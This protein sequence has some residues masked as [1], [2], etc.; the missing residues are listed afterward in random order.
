MHYVLQLLI[1]P[2]YTGKVQFHPTNSNNS[3]DPLD[4]FF[5]GSIPQPMQQNNMYNAINSSSEIYV[6]S[7]ISDHQRV[8]HINTNSIQIKS[9]QF[10]HNI[11]IPYDQ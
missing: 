8:Y 7:T 9:M 11:H 4:T 3:N 6:N 2:H 5:L 1:I 10:N